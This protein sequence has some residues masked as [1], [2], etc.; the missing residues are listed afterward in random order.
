MP[1]Q[2]EAQQLY[3]SARHVWL[4][5]RS[6]IPT[7]LGWKVNAER[8]KCEAQLPHKSDEVQQRLVSHVFLQL[9]SQP[10]RNALDRQPQIQPTPKPPKLLKLLPR[11]LLRLLPRLPL[12]LL[13]RLLRMLLSGL[14]L[15]AM[16][17]DEMK[18][19]QHDCHRAEAHLQ[20]NLNGDLEQQL[21]KWE[22]K[23]TRSLKVGSH[24]V[25]DGHCNCYTVSIREWLEGHCGDCS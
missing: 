12:M 13:P 7:T 17:T 18:K 19:N 9:W 1:P 8:L 24:S 22:H 2:K 20:E 4:S 23:P 3:G 11:L 25:W 15:L 14:R 10:W 6:R 16:L 5:C 21:Q